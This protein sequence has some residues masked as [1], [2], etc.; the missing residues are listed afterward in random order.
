MFPNDCKAGLAGLVHVFAV[1]MAVIA[2][3]I[4]L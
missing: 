3:T 2:Y 4:G 1:N